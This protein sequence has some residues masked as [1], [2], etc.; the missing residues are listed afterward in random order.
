MNKSEELIEAC[1][2]KDEARVP[3]NAKVGNKYKKV[4]VDGETFKDL[5]LIG[6][7]N[8]NLQF[9]RDGQKL[10]HSFNFT[11]QEIKLSWTNQKN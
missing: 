3:S 9:S 2:D 7:T 8:T 5:F 4:V 6:I 10:H 11:E 1:K